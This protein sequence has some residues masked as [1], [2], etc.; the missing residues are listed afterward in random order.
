MSKR[1]LVSTDAAARLREAGDWLLETAGRK[2]EILVLAT[3]PSYDPQRFS[4]EGYYQ[5]LLDD[6]HLPLINRA[7]RHAFPPGSTF[8]LVTGTAALYVMSRY[9]NFRR[10]LRIDPLGSRLGSHA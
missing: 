8:K 4:E 2:G 1:L 7:Y 3:S 10:W 9:T 5:S 6:P